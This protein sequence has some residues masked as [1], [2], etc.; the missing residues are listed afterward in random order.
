MKTFVVGI[1]GGIAS[2]KTAVTDELTALGAS[3]IDADILSR[4]TTKKG[5]VGEKKLKKAF[6]SAFTNGSLDRKSLR[7]L[8]FSSENELKKLNS[9]TH[10]LI[11]KEAKRR[12]RA[13]KGGVLFFA[14]P[15]LFETGFD[16]LCDYTVTVHTDEETRIKRLLKRNTDLTEPAARAIVAAQTSDAERIRRADE[17]IVNDGTTEDLK[18]LTR[19]FYS[20]ITTQKYD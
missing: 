3:V 20:R 10:P 7:E 1:T 11:K 16:A 19:E 13:Q 15:L 2:G 8:V 9:I 5:S 12:I 14:V 4:E 18:R 17:V 6:P